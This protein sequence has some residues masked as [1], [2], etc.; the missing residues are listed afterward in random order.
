[1]YE[2]LDKDWHDVDE[3]SWT[4]AR[5]VN[6]MKAWHDN[7]RIDKTIICGHYH[8]SYGHSRYDEYKLKE[9]PQKNRKNWKDSFKPFIKEG[10][11]A[12]DS[13]VAYSGFCNCLILDED[14]L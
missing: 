2:F 3:F 1:M 11:I 5:W 8:T 10:I 7:V 13:C 12:L 9:W 14:K 4:Q 6:G